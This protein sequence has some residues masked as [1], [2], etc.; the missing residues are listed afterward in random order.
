LRSFQSVKIALSREKG[1]P[2]GQILH[3][4]N[5]KTKDKL[6]FLRLRQQKTSNMIKLKGNKILPYAINQ[7]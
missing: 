2:F 7:L 6:L 5:T 3:L 4:I 1:G